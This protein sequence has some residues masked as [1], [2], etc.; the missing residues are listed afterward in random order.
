[1]VQED[2]I[3]LLD[4]DNFQEKASPELMQKE[5]ESLSGQLGEESGRGGGFMPWEDSD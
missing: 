3:K 5:L 1:M 2:G 4:F